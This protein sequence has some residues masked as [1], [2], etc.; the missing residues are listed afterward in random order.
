MSQELE[1][2]TKK[3]VSGDGNLYLLDIAKALTR[4]AQAINRVAEA[5]DSKKDSRSDAA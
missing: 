1:Q 4:V 5:L 2:G 3:S